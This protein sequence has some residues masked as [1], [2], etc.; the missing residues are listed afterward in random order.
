MLDAEMIALASAAG[1]AVVQAAGT[2]AWESFRQR[3]AA[4]F[5]RGDTARESAELDRLQRSG[6]ELVA[7]RDGGADQVRIRQEAAWQARFEALLESLDADGREQAATGLTA[8]LTEH[9]PVV[10]GVSAGRDSA[11]VGGD[12]HVHAEHGSAAAV[13]MGDVTLGNP[14]RPDA[15]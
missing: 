15:E 13:R 10:R 6:G 14:P 12:A 2:D 9:A 7:V 11:A 4:W 1:T 8:L 3:V 5:G